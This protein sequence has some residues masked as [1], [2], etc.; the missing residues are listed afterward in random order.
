MAQ[1]EVR[2]L[3][4]NLNTIVDVMYSIM[5]TLIDNYMHLVVGLALSFKTSGLPRA[6]AK[7][8]EYLYHAA[9]LHLAYQKL[10]IRHSQIFLS[11]SVGEV[12][13]YNVT[14]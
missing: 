4:K 12:G 6:P 8:P 3:E 13:D 7:S 2:G 11:T 10:F 14:D 1:C 9:T 5:Y